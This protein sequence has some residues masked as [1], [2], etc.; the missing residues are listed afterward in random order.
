MIA[1]TTMAATSGT[2]IP[3]LVIAAVSANVQRISD[4]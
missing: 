3:I 1:I 2:T 4:S